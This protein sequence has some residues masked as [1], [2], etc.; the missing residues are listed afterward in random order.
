MVTVFGS[1]LLGIVKNPQT[2]PKTDSVFASVPQKVGAL[3]SPDIP[4]Q[5]FS[6]GGVRRWAYRTESLTASTTVCSIQTPNATT[7]LVSGNL[8]LISAN[9]ATSSTFT[10][11]KAPTTGSY[12]T[13]INT[14]AAVA[15]A[16]DQVIPFASSSVNA[17]VFQD[18]VFGP[19]QFLNVR[20]ASSTF[21]F[22]P[23][24]ICQATFEQL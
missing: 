18:M 22:S 2:E 6:F 15:S 23:T 7:T 4:Y 24:G 9:V 3:T 20:M 13:P 11:A 1:L 21:T 16:R 10:V 17:Q 5:Y 14:V 8:Y 19:N 12:T